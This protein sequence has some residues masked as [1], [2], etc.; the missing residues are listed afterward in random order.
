MDWR[1][2]LFFHY[3]GKKYSRICVEYPVRQCE[4]MMKIGTVF[5]PE[6]TRDSCA[7]ALWSCPE[8]APREAWIFARQ[9]DGEGDGGR[10]KNAGTIIQCAAERRFIAPRQTKM[11]IFQKIFK[12]CENGANG[13]KKK[14]QPCPLRRGGGGGS[15]FIHLLALEK[16]GCH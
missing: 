11:E 2:V 15:F 10:I 5:L 8:E 4:W 3:I 14:P 13:Q 9:D 1:G 6:G 16:T 12:A 7:E